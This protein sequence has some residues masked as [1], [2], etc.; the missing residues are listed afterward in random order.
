M[1]LGLVTYIET[2]PVLPLSSCTLY[3]QL[4]LACCLV[5][6]LIPIS[7]MSVKSLHSRQTNVPIKHDKP[8]THSLKRHI[9][10][11]GGRGFYAHIQMTWRALSAVYRSV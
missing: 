1:D 3:I 8:G 7:Y 9:L 4:I 2:D 6:V 11:S 10:L 5:T